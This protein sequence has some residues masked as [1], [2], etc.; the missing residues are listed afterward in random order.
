M[1]LEALEV[2]SVPWG[3]EALRA[4]SDQVDPPAPGC[5]E[6]PEVD[7]FLVRGTNQKQGNIKRIHAAVGSEMWSG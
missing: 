3:L 4:Q 7:G 2:Q 5:P 6:H 1:V